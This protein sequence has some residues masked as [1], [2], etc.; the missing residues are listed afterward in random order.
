MQWT[1]ICCKFVEAF[2]SHLARH[3]ATSGLISGAEDIKSQAI[4]R[5]KSNLR[6]SI[7]NRN[8]RI[9]DMYL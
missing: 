1:E 2:R 3:L 6:P 9:R 8:N 5:K 4:E 7:N